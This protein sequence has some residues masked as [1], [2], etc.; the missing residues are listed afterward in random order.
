MSLQSDYSDKA[1]LGTG[2]TQHGQARGTLTFRRVKIRLGGEG[3]RGRGGVID[4]V[5]VVRQ[6][7]DEP[8]DV[9]LLLSPLTLRL[10]SG[11]HRL[12]RRHGLKT[13]WFSPV[14]LRCRIT[15]AV[16]GSNFPRMRTDWDGS[17]LRWG[18]RGI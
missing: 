11:R 9:N 6:D 14:A 1:R 7:Q 13:N 4:M 18:W 2:Q 17:R 15:A 5:E 3:E 10:C 12:V 16:C 8:G